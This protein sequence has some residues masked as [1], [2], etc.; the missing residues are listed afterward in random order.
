MEKFW[1]GVRVSTAKAISLAL[2][3]GEK[4]AAAGEAHLVLTDHRDVVELGLTAHLI[5]LSQQGGLQP[6]HQ[7]F[8]LTLSSERDRSYFKPVLWIWICIRIGSGFN[9]VPGS[10]SGSGFTVRIRIQEGKNYPQTLKKLYKFHFFE[11]LDV[12]F[13]VLKASPPVAWTSFMEA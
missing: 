7:H 12:L 9:G 5:Q 3:C 4:D 11:V 2:T 8:K 13:W 10:I 1:S 6:I